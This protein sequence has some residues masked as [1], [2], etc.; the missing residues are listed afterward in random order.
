MDRD[1]G[2]ASVWSRAY[3]EALRD[4]PQ[5]YFDGSVTGGMQSSFAPSIGVVR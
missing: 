1:L 5:L 2:N 4:S 3:M